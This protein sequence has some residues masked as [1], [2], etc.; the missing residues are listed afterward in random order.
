MEGAGDTLVNKT[1]SASMELRFYSTET[2][3][4]DELNVVS[5]A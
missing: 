1:D 4:A 5:A 3:V 2:R